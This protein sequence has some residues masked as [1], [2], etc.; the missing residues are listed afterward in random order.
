MHRS[1]PR[2]AKNT[3]AQFAARGLEGATNFAVTIL[4]AR[5]LG[6]GPLGVFAFLS[7]Y[8]SLFIF[9]NTFGLNFLMARDVAR[10][11]DEARRYLS[12]A[13][14]MALPLAVIS[15]GLQVG[16][17]NIASTDPAAHT[18]VYLAGAFSVFHSWELLFVGV[19]YALERMELETV[20]IFIE[21]VVLLGAVVALV[22][23]GGGVLAVLG[24]F[25][26]AKLFI[27]VVYAAIS[28]RLIGAPWPAADFAL[29]RRLAA[30]GWAFSLHFLCTTVYLRI[31]VVLVALLATE[32]A[33]G[34]FRAGSVL[35]LS[36]PVIASG[37][38]NALLPLMARAHPGRPGSFMLGLERS[39]TVLSLLGLPMAAGLIVLA[40]PLVRLFYGSHFAPAVFVFQLLGVTVPLK[41]AGNTLG[42]ALTAA[43]RQPQR[44]L[45]EGVG[46]VVTVV[47]SLALIPRLAHTGAAIA[48]AVTDLVIL[49][50]SDT[51]LRR[52][53]Y[54]LDLIGASARP[55][56][57]AAVMAAALWW[58]RG[59][60]VGL[61][62][63]VGVLVFAAAACAVGA[64]RRSDLEW[65]RKSFSS[66]DAP[67]N[68]NA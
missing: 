49:A 26:A 13:L 67:P 15:I 5:I 57:A 63:P 20:G 28:S 42:V 3:I 17:I 46:A 12:N 44:T 48:V 60:S 33:A 62:I 7:T 68:A 56:L 24:V 9:I 37:L 2:V 51:Y 30:E 50:L 34:Y 1:A 11:R 47:L 65:L 55:A 45:V 58:M 61:T 59:M 19:F 21:K 18:G 4:L 31:N 22:F 29:W 25:A 36:L 10:H 53:R 16:I 52:A 35:A 32:Q 64:V 6:V 8:A 66:P 41:F 14:G 23:S 40:Q 38:N 39:F 27:V 54:R 43:D